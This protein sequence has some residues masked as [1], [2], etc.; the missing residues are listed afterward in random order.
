[1]RR[2]KVS[3]IPLWLILADV[4]TIGL[5]VFRDKVFEVLMKYTIGNFLSGNS[6]NTG[7]LSKLYELI[8]VVAIIAIAITII[9]IL[10]NLGKKKQAAFIKEAMSESTVTAQSVPTVI[11]VP[12]NAATQVPSDPNEGHMNLF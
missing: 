3:I 9:M 4:I 1:M 7:L 2:K 6:V 5:W 10:A 11:S 12:A 8:P